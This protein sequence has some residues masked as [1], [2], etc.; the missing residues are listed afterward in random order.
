MY[1]HLWILTLSQ[2]GID[3]YIITFHL[4]T[5]LHGLCFICMHS[6]SVLTINVLWL[7]TTISHLAPEPDLNDFDTLLS[8]LPLF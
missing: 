6:V 4:E 5:S 2:N 8:C 7:M 3:N 1:E